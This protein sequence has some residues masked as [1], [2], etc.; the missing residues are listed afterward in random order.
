MEKSAFPN[1]KAIKHLAQE[2]TQF[3]RRLSGLSFRRRSPG[4][5]R[6][7]KERII[8]RMLKAWGRSKLVWSLGSKPNR[9][10]CPRK[11]CLRTEHSSL[12]ST[13]PLF[14][15]PFSPR[16]I[17]APDS[18]YEPLFAHWRE[19]Q[20]AAAAWVDARNWIRDRWSWKHQ[21]FEPVLIVFSCLIPSGTDEARHTAQAECWYGSA[22]HMSSFPEPAWHQGHSTAR[23]ARATA[24]AKGSKGYCTAVGV[25]RPVVPC[26]ALLGAALR[27]GRWSLALVALLVSFPSHLWACHLHCCPCKAASWLHLLGWRSPWLW[28]LPTWA[29]PSLTW[30]AGVSFFSRDSPRDSEHGA[31]GESFFCLVLC[32]MGKAVGFA[33]FKLYV[34][35]YMC[36]ILCIFCGHIC[37]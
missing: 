16:K 27:T 19:R 14:S 3:V 28:A 30:R 25:C 11:Q 35:S 17:A 23:A 21:C 9:D 31:C 18:S 33:L 15:R 2:R 37:L 34:K 12:L 1:G 6:V 22:G 26:T 36:F 4:R 29:D 20:V 8:R 13:K 7:G 24:A 5:S 32:V 10:V